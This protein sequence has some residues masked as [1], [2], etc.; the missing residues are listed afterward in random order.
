LKNISQPQQKFIK[1]NLQQNQMQLQVDDIIIPHKNKLL[2]FS[3]SLYFLPLGLFQESAKPYHFLLLFCTYIYDCWLY[4]YKNSQGKICKKLTDMIS[5]SCIQV[6][7]NSK[8]RVAQRMRSS[9]QYL[10]KKNYI[11]SYQLQNSSQN[12]LETSY[13]L[14]APVEFHKKI[15]H[16]YQKRDYLGF[17]N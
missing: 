3:S 10:K 5:G 12:I 11:G 9:L 13:L 8:Y 17:T 1:K 16:Y 6:T 2:S 4:D 15:E 14:S 7:E